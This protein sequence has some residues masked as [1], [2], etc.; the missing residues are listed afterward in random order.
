MKKVK[1]SADS[2]CDL[3]KELLEKFEI[4]IQPLHIIL[5]DESYQ[6]G[7]NIKPD[8]IYATYEEKQILPQTA[9]PNPSE[10]IEH[11]KQFTNEGYEVVHISLGSGIS[12]SHHHAK[13]AA[14]EL[15]GV[16]VIDS[17]SLSTGSGHLVLEAALRAEAGMTGEEI[18][19]E[20]AALRHKVHASFIIDKLTYLREGGRCSAL[21]AFS[22]NLLNIRPSIEVDTDGAK[23]D[24]GK[25]YR[26]AMKKVL[27]KYVHDR[28][29]KEDDLRT[30]RIFITHSGTTDDV[31]ELVK[32]EITSHASFDEIYVTRA[33][34]TISSHCGPKTLGILYMTK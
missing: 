3:G 34:C 4:A 7:V 27:K 26:G 19:E 16:Y 15:D 28:L 33:G 32:A 25:K 1:I 30:E 6:D 14:D 29:S 17:G 8:D 11:F 13:L 18:Y 12:S 10:Y 21:Q 31:I 9:A 5:G 22:A 23:M 20:V 2:T 24:V